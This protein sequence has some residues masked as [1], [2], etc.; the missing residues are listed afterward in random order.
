VQDDQLS[1][2]GADITRV[3]DDIEK[4]ALGIKKLDFSWNAIENLEHLDAFV[5][6][7][8]LVVDNNQLTESQ[9]FPQL[10][11]LNTLW[12]NN[13]NISDLERFL[14]EVAAKCPSLT[15]LS[16][17]KNPACPNYFTGKDSDDYRRYRQLVL[18]RLPKLKFLDSSA[19]TASERAATTTAA[20]K[21]GARSSGGGDASLLASIDVHNSA[22]NAAALKSSNGALPSGASV[23][24]HNGEHADDDDDV[25]EHAHVPAGVDTLPTRQPSEIHASYGVSAYSYVGKQSEGN[26]FILDEDL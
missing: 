20:K 17:M 14:T 6:L 4:Y 8:H 5:E 26:R 12:V 1:I 9:V 18:A 10:R 2:V 24:A 21:A 23:D 25:G 3:P 7:T 19:V 13:N 15:Y 22:G 11:N 16:M